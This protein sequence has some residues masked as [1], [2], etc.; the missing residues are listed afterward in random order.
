MAVQA[1]TLGA[2]FSFVCMAAIGGLM[3]SAMGLGEPL[4][5]TPPAQ[6]A[7]AAEAPLAP[8]AAEAPWVDTL[9]SEPASA[10]SM[11]G[12]P[13]VQPAARVLRDGAPLQ[14]AIYAR[15]RTGISLSGAA[16][17]WWDQADGRYRRSHRPEVGA[18]MAMGGTPSGHVAVVARVINDR[19][20]L[21]DHAN[22]LGGGEIIL[23]AQAVDVSEANDWS[24][25]RVWHPPTNALGIRP[26]P[27]Q[28]FIHPDA[29]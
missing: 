28:G 17:V 12:E 8:A 21:I 5:R 22:W 10:P 9:V 27:V 14:C 19:E 23:G 3:L 16:R 13:S 18:V 29:T 6:G 2:I 24:S 4:T 11:P 15:Q 20:I 7:E 25:V 26:Y 1:R